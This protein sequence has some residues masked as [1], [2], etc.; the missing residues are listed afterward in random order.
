MA[1]RKIKV[2]YEWVQ[3]ILN[4]KQLNKNYFIQKINEK[5]LEAFSIGTM[6][7]RVLSKKELEEQRK[8]EEDE[9]A[10]HVSY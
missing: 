3:W 9:A 4:S 2:C 5:K 8:K 6:G 7:K 10:A 1:D